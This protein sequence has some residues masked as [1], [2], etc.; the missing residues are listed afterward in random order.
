MAAIYVE[1][2]LAWDGE[3]YTI[4][5]SFNMV[6]RIEAAGISIMGVINGIHTGQPIASKMGTIIAHMLHSGGARGVTAEQVYAYLASC[7]PQEWLKITT[8]ITTAFL[9]QEPES[10]K[11][12][13]L[14]D[15]GETK[16]EPET[17]S[18]T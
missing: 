7:S 1:I 6:Q 17:P 2:V 14:G 16:A 9:P 4:Q 10:G 15:G 13:A 18:P 12:E 11:S 8:A 5:P 3:E